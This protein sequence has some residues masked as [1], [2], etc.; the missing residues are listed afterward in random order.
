[1]MSIT[2]KNTA[3]NKIINYG[4]GADNVMKLKLDKLG[5]IELD[6]ISKLDEYAT[7]GFRTIMYVM[8]VVDLDTLESG[9]GE[10]F[11]SLINQE[12]PDV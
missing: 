7:N 5:T 10:V 8:K 9:F 12:A 4:K 2:V 3:D 6:M 1:M 11:N